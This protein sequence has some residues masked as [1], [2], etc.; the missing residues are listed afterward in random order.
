MHWY[1]L[2]FTTIP[3]FIFSYTYILNRLIS[4]TNTKAIFY[5]NLPLVLFFSSL[6][7]HKTPFAYLVLYIV[8]IRFFI[9]GKSLGFKKLLGYFAIG[10]GTII[11]MLR[12]YLLDRSFIDVLELVPNY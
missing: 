10:A 6:T 8:L 12:L 4:T 5:L 1:L 9:T 7:M 3:A 2:A 11:A